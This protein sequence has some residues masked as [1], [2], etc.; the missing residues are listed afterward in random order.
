MAGFLSYR[1]DLDMEKAMTAIIVSDSLEDAVEALKVEGHQTTVGFLETLP[2]N[3]GL[4]ER[5]EK[6]REE[7]APALEGIF[8]NDLLD[9]A[10]RA[11]L[12]TR[13]AID[14]TQRM[15]ENNEIREPSRVARD[16]AQVGAQSVEKRL[17][18]QGRPTQIVE[19]RDVSEIVRA[20]EGLGVV[21]LD[22]IESTAEEDHGDA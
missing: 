11:A 9:N 20:L 18:L 22:A 6:R 8:A 14:Q 15:L 17:S 3:P 21:K 12:V 16:L 4:R 2:R 19:H 7:L 13:L 1:N 10:R 5:F